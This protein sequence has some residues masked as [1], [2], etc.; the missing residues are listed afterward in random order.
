MYLN[1]CFQTGE[2]PI[3]GPLVGD[4]LTGDEFNTNEG[5][6]SSP[7]SNQEFGSPNHQNQQYIYPTDQNN[8]GQQQHFSNQPQNF[9]PNQNQLN[10]GINNL[11]INSN[12][13]QRPSSSN[14]SNFNTVNQE[15]KSN[16]S[17]GKYEIKIEFLCSLKL[18]F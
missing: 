3:A 17:T 6:S 16:V 10:A 15:S 11:S 12:S 4:E 1:R 7:P 9:Y 13:N 2:T 5:G 8:F 14:M 18:G